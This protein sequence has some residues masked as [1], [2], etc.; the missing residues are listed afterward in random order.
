M[1]DR[2]EL[3][4]EL[5]KTRAQRDELRDENARLK[6]LLEQHPAIP[7][8]EIDSAIA[9][10]GGSETVSRFATVLL[11]DMNS[12]VFSGEIRLPEIDMT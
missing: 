1:P 5:E 6:R 9:V 7:K 2:D 10:T 11:F 12:L 8:E 3:L 4:A